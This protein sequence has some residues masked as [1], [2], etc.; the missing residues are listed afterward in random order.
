MRIAA[1]VLI[2]VL[3]LGGISLA[4]EFYFSDVANYW[5]YVDDSAGFELLVP[6]DAYA[7]VQ[8]D[9]VG[10][11]S[12]KI[13]LDDKGPALYAGTM[14]GTD[15]NKLWNALSARWTALTDRTRLTT[16]STITTGE[17]LQARFKVLEGSSSGKPTG[18]IRAV[19][20][21][22]DDHMAY[23]A[24]VGNASDYSGDASQY[25]LRAVNSFVWRSN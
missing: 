1:V 25:W 4:G 20:F 23:L 14:P 12:L 24:F 21:T 7:Y 17:G 8:L 13:A 3:S 11:T 2:L 6:S 19:I 9:W 15:V 5:W 10:T 16:D 18:M 22:K